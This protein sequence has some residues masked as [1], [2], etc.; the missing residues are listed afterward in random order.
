V[1]APSLR[2]IDFNKE[3]IL[4]TFTSDTSYASILTQ[5]NEEWDG[6]PISFM[7][8]NLEGVELKYL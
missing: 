6:V 1:E 4:Y 7:I 3:F 2:I 5:K 8:L